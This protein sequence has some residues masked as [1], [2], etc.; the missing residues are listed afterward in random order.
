MAQ[1]RA[2]FE[3]LVLRP[4]LGPLESAFGEYGAIAAQSFG[5]ILARELSS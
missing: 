1:V 4:L 2:Q 3:A 5:E